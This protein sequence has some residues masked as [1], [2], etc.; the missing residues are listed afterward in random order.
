M[1]S[2]RHARFIEAAEH[3][4]TVQLPA[5]NMQVEGDGTRLS[6]VFQ[7][8]LNN[9]AKYTP[10]GGRVTLE[11]ERD[12]NDALICVRDNGIGIPRSCTPECSSCSRARTRGMRSRRADWASDWPSPDSSSSFMAGQITVRS[13]GRN[14]GSEFVVRLPLKV[15]APVPHVLTA[16]APDNVRVNE[17]RVLIVDDN[18]DAAESLAMV[19]QY[20]GVRWKW[21]SGGR[22]HSQ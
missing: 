14:A 13:A 16:D 11:V 20:T 4:L 17:R 8:L 22:K 5:E 15:A 19:L 3:I 2:R 21:R 12:G 10:N 7:N 9:A 18:Q 6:Q 1:P